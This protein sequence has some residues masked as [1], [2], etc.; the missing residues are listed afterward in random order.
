MARGSMSNLTLTFN[1]PGFLVLLLVIPLLWWAGRKSLA[2]MGR[3]RGLVAFGV[4]TV[5]LLAVIL[6]LAEMQ[7]R[8]ERRAISVVYLLDQSLSI[9]AADREAMFRYVARSV[10]KH[11]RAPHGDRAGVIVFGREAAIEVAPV[12]DDLA[13]LQQSEV[14]GSRLAEATNLADALKLAQSIFPHDSARRVVIVTDGNEN[15]GAAQQIAPQF[16]AQGIGIDV[17][18]IRVERCRDVAVEKIALPAICQQGE[19]I[20]A[21]VVI[22]NDIP[23]TSANSASSVAGT[24]RVVRRIGGLAETLSEQN[25][26]LAPGKN[27]LSMVHQVDAPAG[28]CTYEA[29]FIPA[30]GVGDRTRQNDRATAFTHIK[31]KGRVL[32]IEN[33]DAPGEYNHLIERLRA[34]EI[35]LDVR[36]SLEPF[37][38]LAELQMYDAVVLANVA[39]TSGREAEAIF[40]DEQI[41]ILLRN[42]QMGGGLVML[43]GPNSFGA[44]GWANTRLEEASPVDFEVKNAKVVPAGALVLV[45]DKSGSMEGEK[46]KMSRRAAVEALRV[47]GVKD[48]I[49]VVAFDGGSRWVV[50]MNQIGQLRETIARR[51]ARLD[52]GGGTNMFPGMEQ[53]YRALRSVDAAVKHMIILTDGK[54]QP[55]DFQQV[56]HRM[57]QENITVSTVAIG[58]DADRRLLEGVA[59]IG[60]GKSYRVISPKAVPRIFVKEAMRV[61]KPLVYE[62]KSGISPQVAFPHEMLGGIESSFPPITGFVLTQA[63]QN[64][65]V[66]VILRS[67]HPGDE[68]TST[69][70]ASWNY[71]LGR[72][73]VLTTDAGSRWASAWTGWDQYDAFFSQI[74]RWAM[75]PSS[76]EGNL[77]VSTEVDDDCIRV[78][79]TALDKNDEFINSLGMTCT[80]TTPDLQTLNMAMEQTAPGRYV[81]QLDVETAG[82]YFLAVNG[83]PQVGIA[84][85]GVTV[86]YSPE[87]KD[88]EIN[89]PL[90]QSLAGQQPAGGERGMLVQGDLLQPESGE[91]QTFD[92]FRPTLQPAV[93]LHDAWHLLAL[94][95]ACLFL[96]DVLNRRV[97]LDPKMA[98]APLLQWLRRTA[99]AESREERIHRLQARKS[100]IQQE[101]EKRRASVRFEP[102]SESGAE[103]RHE[104]ELGTRTEAPD[105]SKGH[106]ADRTD[107]PSY[108]SRLLEAKRKLQKTRSTGDPADSD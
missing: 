16:A 36:S 74:V 104:E 38:T 7:T 95:A 71:G 60:G 93:S 63:K 101:I 40:T 46:I 42:T 80:V 77:I 5:V 79:V 18:P 11:R 75:R 106:E 10:E 102:S 47:L 53:G 96:F 99:D 66:D 108:T 8:Q 107:E 98:L 69:L 78:V 91:L 31:G 58:A 44:G 59:Q 23:N 33:A 26:E 85:A 32:F 17:V 88:R 12:E 67:S 76:E 22:D 92:A 103:S 3:I 2:T 87:F 89:R 35:L 25:V 4:R 45:I 43:G 20:D 73:V 13:W 1:S 82:S 61:A 94:L 65:L 14:A 81:G 49:G 24:L 51:I 83:G 34:A 90:L 48:H 9:P 30:E 56:A 27:I 72:F 6:A 97:L 29:Q 15:I 41:E 50:R 68:K 105:L 39:R 57:R 21:R 54:T 37:A 62:R 86:P 84:R 52:A 70:L 19:T 55:G 100:A 28:F 64:P